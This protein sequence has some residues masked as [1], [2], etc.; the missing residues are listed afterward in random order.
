MEKKIKRTIYFFIFAYL[1]VFPQNLLAEKFYIKF[2]FFT[3]YG[4]NLKDSVLCNTQYFDYSIMD[5]VDNKLGIGVYLELIYQPFPNLGFSISNSYSS[6]PVKGKTYKFSP[7]EGSYFRQKYT[8]LPE[9]LSEVIPL[10]ISIIYSIPIISAFKINLFGGVDY[11]FV[12]PEGNSEI[13]IPLA[14]GTHK[15]KPRN[16]K[17]NANG[18]GIHIGAGIDI[19]L[20]TETILSLDV[21]YMTINLGSIKSSADYGGDTTFSYL[22]LYGGSAQVTYFDYCATELD[23]SGIIFRVGLKFKL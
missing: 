10:T 7:V 6:I 21:Q 1:F 12:T 14:Y 22:N 4:G 23:L 20:P 16:F 9:I 3:H 17:G 19:T 11:F 5:Q 2:A 13:E 8:L 15:L 18:S